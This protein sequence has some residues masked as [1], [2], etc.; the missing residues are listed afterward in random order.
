MTLINSE[1]NSY[2]CIRMNKVNILKTAIKKFIKKSL[3]FT[4]RSGRLFDQLEIDDDEYEEI[5]D[6]MKVSYAAH[7]LEDMSYDNAVDIM[8]HLSKR[9][10]AT[11]LAIMDK[12]MQKKLKH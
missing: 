12:R 3:T 11:L 8:N 6:Q 7:I 10:I 9:K 2:P 5:F 4:K 1:K